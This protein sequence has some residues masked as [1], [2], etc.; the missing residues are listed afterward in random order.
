MDWELEKLSY[1][2]LKALYGSVFV[3]TL[4]NNTEQPKWV[5]SLYLLLG[6]EIHKREDEKRLL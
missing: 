4:F 6:T 2:D 5:H 3:M 1:S